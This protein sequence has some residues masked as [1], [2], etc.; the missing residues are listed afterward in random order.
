[1]ERQDNEKKNMQNYKCVGLEDVHMNLKT[2]VH[3][4]DKKCNYIHREIHQWDFRIFLFTLIDKIL[5]EST[6]N[7]FNM[8][9]EY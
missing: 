1:M 3:D 6:K 8:K 9:V 4:K 2:K 5:R 7:S